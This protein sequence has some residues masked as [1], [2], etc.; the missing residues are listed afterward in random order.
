MIYDCRLRIA[1]GNSRRTA[2]PQNVIDGLG[3]TRAAES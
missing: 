3:S 2:Q 1:E